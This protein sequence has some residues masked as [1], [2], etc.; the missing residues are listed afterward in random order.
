MKKLALQKRS[1]SEQGTKK[2]PLKK[3]AYFHFGKCGEFAM[4]GRL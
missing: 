1:R 3:G 4:R 2:K